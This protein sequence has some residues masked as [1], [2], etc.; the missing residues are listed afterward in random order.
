MGLEYPMTPVWRWTAEQR[1]ALDEEANRLY[2]KHNPRPHQ[3]ISVSKDQCI[4]E[5]LEQIRTTQPNL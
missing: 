4:R 1:S 5:A 2:D 3:R